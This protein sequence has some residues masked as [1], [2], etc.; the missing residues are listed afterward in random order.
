MSRKVFGCEAIHDSPD[1]RELGTFVKGGRAKVL[2]NLSHVKRILTVAVVCQLVMAGL[3]LEIYP[4]S[5]STKNLPCFQTTQLNAFLSM[6]VLEGFIKSNVYCRTVASL[7][8]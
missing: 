4:D 2:S 1:R 5:L 7:F 8:R 6:S 3:N